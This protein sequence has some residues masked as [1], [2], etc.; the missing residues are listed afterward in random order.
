MGDTKCRSGTR[1][2]W[3]AIAEACESATGPDRDIDAR[4]GAAL[5][6]MWHGAYTAS[7]D[8]I[9]AAIG[10]RLPGWHWET[11]A[12]RC[13]LVRDPA[14]ALGAAADHVCWKAAT[15]A[16]ALCAAFCRAMAERSAADA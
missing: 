5:G 14:E 4:V 8:A 10:E 1:S 16:L 9:T 2:E 3:L 11:G 13:A 15:P 12:D 7:L 6:I